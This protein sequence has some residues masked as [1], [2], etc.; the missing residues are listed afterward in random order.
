M[1]NTRE[2]THRLRASS[3]NR[4]AKGSGAVTLAAAAVAM[5]SA[6]SFAE[7]GP[8][9]GHHDRGHRGHRAP[10]V[11]VGGHGISVSLDVCGID[12]C[13]KTKC[14][15]HRVRDAGYLWINGRSHRI[16]NRAPHEQILESFRCLGY[17]AW[18][19]GDKVVVRVGH[20]RPRVTWSTRDYGARIYR[21]GD[22]ITIKP[23]KRVVTRVIHHNDNRFWS[24]PRYRDHGYAPAHRSPIVRRPSYRPSRR[25]S[26]CW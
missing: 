4:S 1:L 26:R 16:T 21:H 5:L 20:R 12:G 14:T 2:H 7:A 6:A 19:E 23:Y 8:R 24:P 3:R 25:P 11:Q 10:I 22:C 9:H 17:E 15:H 13:R 18:C